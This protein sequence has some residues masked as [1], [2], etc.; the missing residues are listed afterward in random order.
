MRSQRTTHVRTA[1]LNA[2][3]KSLAHSHAISVNHARLEQALSSQIA[4]TA[5][6]DYA[7][8]RELVL[9]LGDGGL[10]SQSVFHVQVVRDVAQLLL[11]FFDGLEISGSVEGIAAKE[12]ETD[13]VTSDITASHVNTTSLGLETVAFKDG[14]DVGHTIT[15]IDDDTAHQGLGVQ[16]KDGLNGNINTLKAVLFKLETVSKEGCEYTPSFEA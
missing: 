10:L 13:K 1:L 3:E 4:L 7:T 14:H 11:D 5:N 16:G 8:I 6:G 9:L 15:R 2:V 12:E